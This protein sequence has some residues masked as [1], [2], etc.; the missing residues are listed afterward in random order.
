MIVTEQEARTKWCPH[1]RV[2]SYNEQSARNRTA[3]GTLMAASRCMASACMAWKW[4]HN[5]S[6]E[7]R[8]ERE[9]FGLK[10]ETPK[11]YCGL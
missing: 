11:G 9:K 1:A 2:A 8:Q 10:A 4:K 7:E 5:H 6:P 3:D